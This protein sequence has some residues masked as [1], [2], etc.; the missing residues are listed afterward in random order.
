MGNV[1]SV[2][3]LKKRMVIWRVLKIASYMLGFLLLFHLVYRD[4]HSLSGPFL[5]SVAKL[6]VYFVLGAWVAVAVAQ[7]ICALICKN[8]LAK[9]IVV[10]IVG[11]A[12]IAGPLV[13]AEFIIAPKFET[14]AEEYEA[15]GLSFKSYGVQVIEYASLAED[16]DA[17]VSDF[18]EL[19]NIKY[20]SKVY[21]S[22]NTDTSAYLKIE[23]GTDEIDTEFFITD[24]VFGLDKGDAAYS[25]NG[26]YAD[27]YVFGY[28]Q[29]RYILETYYNTQQKYIADGEDADEALNAAI[30]ALTSNPYSDWNIYKQSDE[31]L[32]FYGDDLTDVKNAKRYFV[33][34][35][36]LNAILGALGVN[37]GSGES[38][39]S[40][41][42]IISLI[43]AAMGGVIPGD[44]INSINGSLTLDTI[45][46]IANGFGLAITEEQIM[47][48]LEGFSNYQSPQ[49]KPVFYFIEDAELRDYAYAKYVG[50]VHGGKVGSVLIGS[51]IGEITMDS[52]GEPAENLAARM[53]MFKRTEMDAEYMSQY[54]PF[55]VLRENYLYFAGLIPFSIACAYLFAS[56]EK[57]NLNKLIKGGNR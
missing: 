43:N 11:F 35:E 24:Y 48:L 41:S 33:T 54:F 6:P 30:L 51:R 23:K 8:K 31:Y 26:M 50:E 56:L 55:L 13:Y 21:G 17:E 49:T 16:L 25:P 4:A 28:A 2:N 18:L 29:A 39:S 38:Q 36:R 53:V 10:A 47:N 9:I 1:K 42:A 12:V 46:T 15:E 44:I 34:A 3:S 7:I 19:Y 40:L 52:Q 5:S 32:E 27:G 14:L 37:L 22:V 20:E 57:K 45:L